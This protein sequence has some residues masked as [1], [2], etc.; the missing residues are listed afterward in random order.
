MMLPWAP[1]P[2]RS[3]LGL[4]RAARLSLFVSMAIIPR[5]G[6]DV[7]GGWAG[8]AS[9]L[10]RPLSVA[11]LAP[12]RTEELG[13]TAQPLS[14]GAASV[15]RIATSV[16][17]IPQSLSVPAPCRALRICKHNRPFTETTAAVAA[18]FSPPNQGRNQVQRTSKV[19]CTCPV[20]SPRCPST[21]PTL[22]A[23]GDPRAI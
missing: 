21:P 14:R 18:R 5:L 8:S 9:S 16:S 19:R 12:V 7:K 22:S 4:M 17:S 15:P 23:G 1:L 11:V 20:S 13:K 6:V 10:H 2:P 3:C